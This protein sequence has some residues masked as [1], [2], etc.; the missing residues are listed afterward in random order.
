MHP[1]VQP[2]V[3]SQGGGGTL[4]GDGFP[5]VLVDGE[6][7]GVWRLT[8]KDGA[9]V[10]LFDAVG[11]RTRERIDERIGTVAAVLMG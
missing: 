5:V 2:R 7:V 8:T 3:Y 10:E 4:P 1:D 11:M 6:A 9:S